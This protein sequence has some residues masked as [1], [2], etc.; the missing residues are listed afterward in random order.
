MIFFSTFEK[1][2]IQIVLFQ[3]SIFL[4]KRAYTICPPKSFNTRLHPCKIVFKVLQCTIIFFT[5]IFLKWLSPSIIDL[6][7]F[8]PIMPLA[9]MKNPEF[10]LIFNNGIR[11]H[12]HTHTS[13][14]K[15]RRTITYKTIE[16]CC[17]LRM[18]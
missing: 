9:K 12:T 17:K 10:N 15:E 8:C 4:F 18:E 13:T 5:L 2:Q 7:P 6:P 11:T 3:W 16:F 1:L 14:H